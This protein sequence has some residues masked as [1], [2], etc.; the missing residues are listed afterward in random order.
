MK[1]EIKSIDAKKVVGNRL[2]MSH[3]VNRTGDLWRTFMPLKPQIRNVVS[4]DLLSITRYDQ[5]PDFQKF[6]PANEFEK[7]AAVEVSEFDEVSEPMASHTIR[8]GLYAVFFYKGLSTDPT[9]FRYIFGVWLPASEYVLDDREHFEVLG[10]RYKNND[11]E[12]QEEIWIPIR[13]K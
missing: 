13:S 11:P 3:V 1:F 4:A 10:N 7:W 12:S 2:R 5:V 6:D 8:G 9:P